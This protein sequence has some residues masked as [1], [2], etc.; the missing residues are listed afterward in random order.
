MRAE[1]K[2]LVSGKDGLGSRGG[3]PFVQLFRMACVLLQVLKKAAG[4]MSNYEGHGVG[5]MGK[6]GPMSANVWHSNTISPVN[7]VASLGYSG[8]KE[9]AVTRG[10]AAE[11]SSL[12]GRVCDGAKGMF[13]KVVLQKAQVYVSGVFKHVY[14]VQV[15]VC[16]GMHRKGIVLCAE[17]IVGTCVAGIRVWCGGV[18]VCMW[19][20]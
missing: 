4:E 18:S 19:D 1:R 9:V 12:Q 17:R 14:G 6:F 20:V 7:R 10:L 2:Q 16:G 5:V 15:H 11:P 3:C 8:T 13:R